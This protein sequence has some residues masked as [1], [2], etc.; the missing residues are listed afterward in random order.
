MQISPKD[1]VLQ[2]LRSHLCKS[3]IL[4]SDDS[5]SNAFQKQKKS[6]TSV[7]IIPD[8]S[9]PFR[10]HRRHHENTQKMHPNVYYASKLNSTVEKKSRDQS[11][12]HKSS[13]RGMESLTVGG[14]KH[15]YII[16]TSHCYIEYLKSGT[17]LN[18]QPGW[19]LYYPP[20][21]NQEIN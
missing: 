10:T 17:L 13:L 1:L 11:I 18:P 16:L 12:G 15:S 3:R 7:P 6:L 20:V 9:L 4:R 21:I 14:D 2:L 19:C 5:A 8:S